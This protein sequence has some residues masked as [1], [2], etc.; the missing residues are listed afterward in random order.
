MVLPRLGASNNAVLMNIEP[1]AALVL[2][3]FILGQTV[4]AMQMLGAVIVV[5][6]IVYQSFQR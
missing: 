5:S 1:V 3:F 2:G 4:S 6:A